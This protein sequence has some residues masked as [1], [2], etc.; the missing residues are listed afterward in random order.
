MS[1]LTG[2]MSKLHENEAL[3]FQMIVRPASDSWQKEGNSHLKKFFA[4]HN[5]T[6]KDGKPTGD[7]MGKIEEDY[8]QKV[9]AKVSKVGFE[10]VIR[11]VSVSED[12]ASAKANL[13]NL[14]RAF[15]QYNS[16]VF[17]NFKKSKNKFD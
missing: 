15:D 9:H 10:T 2:A 13:S 17:N 6:D 7:R 5:K 8:M 14:E 11:I 1:V 16:P 4:D 3:A 12:E